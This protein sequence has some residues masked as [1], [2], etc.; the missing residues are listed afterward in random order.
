[1][2]RETHRPTTRRPA[3]TAELLAYTR[4]NSWAS[5][6]PAFA[7]FVWSDGSQVGYP[8]LRDT[9]SWSD[10]KQARYPDISIPGCDR[11]PFV[12]WTADEEALLLAGHMA[13]S[14]TGFEYEYLEG[15]L[16]DLKS[17]RT[18]NVTAE[19]DDAA[20]F[21]MTGRDVTW[22]MQL[23]SADPRKYLVYAVD[24]TL[25]FPKN[26]FTRFYVWS[27]GAPPWLVPTY[28]P[29]GDNADSRFHGV[30]VDDSADEHG[31]TLLDFHPGGFS[32]VRTLTDGIQASVEL[33]SDSCFVPRWWVPDESFVVQ[34]GEN[35]NTNDRL[36]IQWWDDLVFY[37]FDGRPNPE[38]SLVGNANFRFDR[39]LTGAA[40][41]SN[42]FV[43]SKQWIYFT[44]HEALEPET[45]AE[46]VFRVAPANPGRV[47]RLTDFNDEQTKLLDKRYVCVSSGGKK[48]AFVAREGK[49]WGVYVKEI[50]ST[51]E[52]NRVDQALDDSAYYTYPAFPGGSSVWSKPSFR[53]NK[54][55]RSKKS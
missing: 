50:G 52:P 47:E 17:G 44:A 1:M 39:I 6:A 11:A 43:I 49:R 12:A 36:H 21:P 27:P 3:L 31:V 42:V 16:Y 7:K 32:E 29:P 18:R 10:G 19:F 30:A 55:R 8:V 14:R 25:Q 48:I 51:A 5:N 33:E 40:H 22:N 15:V 38:I 34:V 23:L 2:K 28:P 35:D 4:Y 37:Y 24:M 9:F 20:G 54:S 41:G 46:D 53:K 45:Y 26:R 13:V